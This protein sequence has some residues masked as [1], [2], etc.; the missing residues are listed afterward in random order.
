MQEFLISLTYPGMR[1]TM[2]VF[3]IGMVTMGVLYQLLKLL[4]EL[5][6]AEKFK[7][8][9]RILE[10]MIYSVCF[11]SITI[12]LFTLGSMQIGAF[13]DDMFSLKTL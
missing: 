7:R 6:P 4:E 1:A 11:L 13:V 3:F 9:G 12:C 2:A 5:M 10:I 8:V